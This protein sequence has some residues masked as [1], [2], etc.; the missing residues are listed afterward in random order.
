MR[1]EEKGKQDREGAAE[2]EN[3]QASG[4]KSQVSGYKRPTLEDRVGTVKFNIAAEPHLK[5]DQQKCKA[6]KERVCLYVCPAGNYT[7]VEKNEAD[8]PEVVLSWEGCFECGTC[9]LA[10]PHGAIDWSYPTGSK[11]VCYRYG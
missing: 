8:P 6:C 5:L 11:G 4:L 3:A 1:L 9:R 2:S 10:C 7:E